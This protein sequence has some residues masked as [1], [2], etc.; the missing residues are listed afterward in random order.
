MA[1]TDYN[2]VTGH[3]SFDQNG[4]TTNKT[5]SIYQLADISGQPNW[6]YLTA[7]TLP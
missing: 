1:K 6:K 5:I 2:G 7:Q 3:H 4:D